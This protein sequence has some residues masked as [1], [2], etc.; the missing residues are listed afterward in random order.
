ML[1]FNC[2]TNISNKKSAKSQ[3]LENCG[4]QISYF[5]F[6]KPAAAS[7]ACGIPSISF[8]PAVAKNG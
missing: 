8:P 4:L 1:A 7:K 6:I 5:Y 3:I 2:V